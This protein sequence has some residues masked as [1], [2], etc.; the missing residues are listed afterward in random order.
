[1]AV[2]KGENDL[3]WRVKEGGAVNYSPRPAAEAGTVSS[4]TNNTLLSFSSGIEA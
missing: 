1:M 2:A 3:E 4:S